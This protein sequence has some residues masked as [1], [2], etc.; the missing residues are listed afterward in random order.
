L[1][2]HRGLQITDQLFESNLTFCDVCVLNVELVMSCNNF[3]IFK[4]DFIYE[5]FPM[6]SA[7]SP[8]GIV[9][10]LITHLRASRTW[11]IFATLLYQI[12]CIGQGGAGGGTG[13]ATFSAFIIALSKTPELSWEAHP[14]RIL[15]RRQ[16]SRRRG[17]LTVNKIRHLDFFL[18]DLRLLPVFRNET[19][20][21]IFSGN[22]D[23]Q[24]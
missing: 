13:R 11:R 24:D 6:S 23:W 2:T 17:H 3:K 9:R 4:F 14:R 21:K 1:W 19:V 18:A 5:N 10:L 16:K 12:W 20:I 15:P 7:S 22:W 8:P